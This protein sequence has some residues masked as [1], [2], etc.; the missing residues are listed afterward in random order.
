MEFDYMISG[1]PFQSHPFS[2]SEK[3]LGKYNPMHKY[4][5]KATQQE[6]RLVEKDLNM[7]QQCALVAKAANGIL[8]SIRKNC[9]KAE[10]VILRLYS[11]L[12]RECL[13]CFVQFW[14]PQ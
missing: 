5:L 4:M 11:V 9:Q 6:N 10:E 3:Q 12:V 1:S 7:S 2:V 14:A 13:E 8:G